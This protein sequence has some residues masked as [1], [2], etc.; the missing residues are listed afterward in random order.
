MNFVFKIMNLYKILGV[1]QTALQIDIAKAYRKLVMLYHPD[2]NPDTENTFKKIQ[3]A[4]DILSDSNKRANYDGKIK[5]PNKRP[6]KGDGFIYSDAPPAKVDIWG[7]KIEPEHQ[8]I[9]AYS[10]TYESD[11]QPDIR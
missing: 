2:R 5:K 9:D 3:E 1:P 4:Y 11:G 10:N 8:W 6:Y 7:Q